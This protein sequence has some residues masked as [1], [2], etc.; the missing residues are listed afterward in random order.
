MAVLA[1]VLGCGAGV[2]E[3]GVVGTVGGMT[4]DTG[5][6]G[7]LPPGIGRARDGVLAAEGLDVPAVLLLGVTSGAERIRRLDQPLRVVAGVRGVAG[8]AAISIERLVL[9]LRLL[10]DAG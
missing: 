4:A 10:A 2:E 6:V 3:F 5:E 7:T 1:G 9:D 8:G